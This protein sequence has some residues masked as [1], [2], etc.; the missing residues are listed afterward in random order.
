MYNICH[1]CLYIHCIFILYA[2]ED[3]LSLV[4]RSPGPFQSPLAGESSKY[5]RARKVTLGHVEEVIEGNP[6]LW[7]WLNRGWGTGLAEN[8]ELA[9][10]KN[11]RMKWI[12][13]P[14]VVWLACWKW[15]KTCEWETLHIFEVLWKHR[16]IHPLQHST[17]AWE[18]F[19]MPVQTGLMGFWRRFL[20]GCSA[21]SLEYLLF[22][23]KP[24]YHQ[25]QTCCGL[26][27][28][29]SDVLFAH[30]FIRISFPKTGWRE[31]VSKSFMNRIYWVAEFH[32]PWIVVENDWAAAKT[33]IASSYFII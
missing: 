32:F 27:T 28:S 23:C 5:F 14:C 11:N 3:Q 30:K 1:I 26:G 20:Y 18:A 24:N 6:T 31:V 12:I 13:M 7:L 15:G 9:K 17:W 19:K 16:Q 8:R 29:A 4:S 33:S 10:S 2:A 25:I 21:P 22:L